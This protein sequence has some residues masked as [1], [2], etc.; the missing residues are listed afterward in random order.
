MELQQGRVW[1]ALHEFKVWSLQ[2]L[3]YKRSV[4]GA[5][6]DSNMFGHIGHQTRGL[7]LETAMHNGYHCARLS[8]KVSKPET[9][10]AAQVVWYVTQPPR[11]P[12]CVWGVWTESLHPVELDGA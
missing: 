7:G 3:R 12:K 8:F 1:Y 6:H 10:R 4:H 9:A 11:R 5:S 2:T